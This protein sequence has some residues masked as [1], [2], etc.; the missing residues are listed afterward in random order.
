MKP[1]HYI[2]T[3]A[4]FPAGKGRH[5]AE[6][7]SI[8]DADSPVANELK[9]GYAQTKWA[10]ENLIHKFAVATGLPAVVYRLGNL[11]GSVGPDGLATWNTR[12]SNLE[13]VRTCVE[14]GMVPT[15]TEGL[16]LELTPVDVVSDFIVD[17]LWDIRHTNGKVFH[18]IQPNAIP[19]AEVFT[20]LRSA[21]YRVEQCSLHAWPTEGTFINQDTVKEL[22]GDTNTYGVGNSV[23]RIPSGKYFEVGLGTFQEYICGLRRAQLLPSAP[24]G[25]LSGMVI[26][27]VGQPS[28]DTLQNVLQSQGAVVVP[29][30]GFRVLYA[31]SG[32]DVASVVHDVCL[33]IPALKGVKGAIVTTLDDNDVGERGLN[34]FLMEISR[35]MG[36]P[37]VA[38]PA[39]SSIDSVA[40]YVSAS[41]KHQ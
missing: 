34:A 7:F 15:E 22:C 18:L 10:A 6:D 9:S 29:A 25:P 20:C 12:D 35:A 30:G 28:S 27:L 41:A 23:S 14:L 32:C 21:G 36:F 39:N 26:S 4:V 37:M 33:K 11:G 13:F 40:Q 19:M 16:H 31:A 24:E 2:S 1:L 5:F 8:F 3:D 38:L 17:C